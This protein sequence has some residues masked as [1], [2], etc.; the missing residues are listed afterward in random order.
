MKTS[1]DVVS[2]AGERFA[3]LVTPALKYTNYCVINELEAQQ[4]TGVRLRDEDGTLHIENME[5]AL[6]KL[7]ERKRSTT[8]RIHRFVHIIP[9]TMQQLIFA[10]IL[11]FLRSCGGIQMGSYLFAL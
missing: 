3:K 7:K 11:P 2:E 4:T 10:F 8:A 1:I 5:S 9:D 6:R